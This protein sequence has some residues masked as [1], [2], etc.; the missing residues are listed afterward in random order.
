MPRRVALVLLPALLAA[1]PAAAQGARLSGVVLDSALDALIAGADAQLLDAARA[2]SPP[3]GARSDSA[4]RFDFAGL[5]AGR[6]LLG[7]THARLDAFGLADVTRPVTLAEGGDSTVTLAGPTARAARALHCGGADT[8]ATAATTVAVIGWLRRDGGAGADPAAV[9]ARWYEF[10]LDRG[11]SRGP[12]ERRAA[13]GED[14]WFALCD[15][16]AGGD[17]VLHGRRGADSTDALRLTLPPAGVLRRDLRVAPAGTTGLVLGAVRT[18]EGAP[19]ANAVATVAGAPPARTDAG[20]AFR[21]DGAPAGTRM[22]VVRAVGYVPEERV[23]EARPA[24][25]EPVEVR[26]QSTR[27]LLDTIRV[28]ATRDN[29]VARRLGEFAFRRKSIGAGTAFDSLRLRRTGATRA[30]DLF[31]QVP[32]A[33]LVTSFDP[34]MQR[35]VDLLRVRGVASVLGVALCLPLVWVDRT[36]YPLWADVRELDQFLRVDDV[37][38]FEFY[39]GGTGPPEFTRFGSC[40]SAI[41]TTRW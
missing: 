27:A 26:L 8:A 28:R 36:P 25:G 32:G 3:A 18:A 7:F 23:V 22:L 29:P 2:A 40:G 6:Y 39:P 30:S 35:D 38:A 37:I 17:V 20:G 11:F 1:R 10:R 33:S 5:A 31:R 13:V 9:V 16:P 12:V 24:D 21:L 4:G 14:G 34:V 19:I 41:F 15:L